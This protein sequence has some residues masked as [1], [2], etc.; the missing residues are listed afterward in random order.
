MELLIAA[1]ISMF[2]LAGLTEFLSRSL[3][4]SGRNLQDARLTQDLNV[5]MDLITRD[6]R[7][8]GYSNAAQGLTRAADAIVN[9][10][11]QDVVGPNDGGISL[12]TPGCVLYAYDLPAS[13]NGALDPAEQLG[14]RLQAGAVEAGTS[15]TSCTAGT[16]QAVTDPGV[17]NV[18][19]LTFQYLDGAG[20]VAA[21]PFVAPP[22]ASGVPW[23]VC[24]RLIQVTLTGQLRGDT[25]VTYT[26]TQSVRVRNDWYRAGAANCT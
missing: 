20:A 16:W 17:S 9:P 3:V 22:A 15:V 26:L 19:V 18:T 21:A 5:A 4:T 1:A 13:Q 12:A 24:T 6:L 23:A 14:F 2:L 11:T 7:R 25:N 8:A 10:F